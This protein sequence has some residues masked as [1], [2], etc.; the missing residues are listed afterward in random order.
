MVMD[1]NS[2]TYQNM[3]ERY[4][5]MADDPTGIPRQ[6][7]WLSHSRADDRYWSSLEANYSAGQIESFVAWLA[8]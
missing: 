5:M 2:R 1:I 6:R 8:G 7:H 3:L 4:R